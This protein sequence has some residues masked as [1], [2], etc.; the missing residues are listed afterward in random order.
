MSVATHPTDTN[1]SA[2]SRSRLTRH[3]LNIIGAAALVIAGAGVAGSLVV[4]RPS[5]TSPTTPL[6]GS[7][8]PTRDQWYLETLSGPPMQRSALLTSAVKDRWYADAPSAGSASP[9]VPAGRDR[10]YLDPPAPP[11]GS[12]PS[13]QP[14]DRWYLE[15]Q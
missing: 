2:P 8:V 15:G 10:W 13:A 11:H 14:R 9:I 5:S 6:A 12:G 4:L 1:S 3:R 7:A